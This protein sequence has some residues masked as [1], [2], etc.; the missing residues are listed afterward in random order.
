MNKESSQ[1][2]HIK[3]VDGAEI[4]L[5]VDFSGQMLVCQNNTFNIK[6]SPASEKCTF[7]NKNTWRTAWDL[8]SARPGLIQLKSE[9]QRN[10]KRTAPSATSSL[11]I[12]H[13]RF[14][15]ASAPLRSCRSFFPSALKRC[16][17]FRTHKVIYAQALS[18]RK[19]TKAASPMASS[20]VPLEAKSK[21][22]SNSS[23]QPQLPELSQGVLSREGRSQRKALRSQ[24][25]SGQPPWPTARLIRP[26]LKPAER[27]YQMPLPV[28]SISFLQHYSTFLPY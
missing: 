9:H 12:H 4:N 23:E 18:C 19:T 28:F 22:L 17:S 13:T 16:C 14:R 10:S 25:V 3:G 15:R 1:I 5:L 6:L 11:L 26:S 27:N 8:C 20:F 21:T 7:W 24:R 2:L